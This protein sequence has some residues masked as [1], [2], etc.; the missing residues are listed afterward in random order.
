LG[1]YFVFLLNIWRNPNLF[2]ASTAY[3]LA[4][5]IQSLTIQNNNT[6]KAKIMATMQQIQAKL[7]E[8]SKKTERGASF[9][10]NASFP[11]WNIP[12]GST[13]T[14]RFLP[15]GN[16]NNTFFWVEK[17]NI[18]LK[19]Q[20]VVGDHDREITISVPCVEMFG[21]TCPILAETRP[22]WKDPAKETLA[23]QY[24]KK[25]SY[26]FQG[27]VVSS[28]DGV[29][30][31]VPANPIRR[32]VINPSIY[33]IIK[34]SLM[35]PEME[36]MPADYEGGRDFKLTKTKKGE[37]ANYTTSQ[38]SFKT[39]SLG[40][41]ERI[42]IE[43]FGLFNLEEFRGRR[44]DA[45]ERDVIKSMFHDSLAGQPFDLV[46]YGKFYRPY[47]TAPAV[48]SDTV[49]TVVED[50]IAPKKVVSK[51]DEPKAETKTD[52]PNAHQILERIKNRSISQG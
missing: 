28:P 35:N 41:A 22:W 33:E 27:F 31:E 34:N 15:D 5:I 32:F 44:P 23:R 37:Y 12:E 4:K 10:D 38:W 7:L 8:E 16:S 47:G 45:E 18:K 21:D 29:E 49:S 20:G 13:A 50:V 42:A 6:R 52:K 2:W 40:E 43:Q 3:L 1:Y 51:D 30:T 48:T 36:D 46:S 39:R 9:G 17:Q 26:L 24:W 14:I 19:F 25:K 11:F